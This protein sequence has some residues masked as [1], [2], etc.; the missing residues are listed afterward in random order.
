MS[1]NT[2]DPNSVEPNVV[3]RAEWLAARVARR[4]REKELTRRRDELAAARRALPWVEVDAPYVFHTEQGPRSLLDL[5][6]GR[7]QLLLWHF[8]F[9]PGW[10]EGCPSCSFWADG[11]DGLLP[12]LAARDT[13]L[14]VVSRAPLDELLAYRQR[15]GWTFPWVS[16]KGSSF[17]RDF[18]V[19]D[20]TTYNY[21]ELDEPA[22]ELPGLSVFIRRNDRV[23]HSYSA[24]A[25]GVDP[26]NAAYAMLDV[27]PMGRHEDDLPWSMAWLRRHD[28][29]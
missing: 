24:Y 29:Y 25:R 9:G 27:T 8:M 20:T 5:F 14:V 4:D 12:H 28:Q 22:D 18:A 11:Y 7:D 13:S 26:F 19:S 6:D 10:E 21:A 2:V 17:N 23:F 15:M 16:S 1:T 3:S